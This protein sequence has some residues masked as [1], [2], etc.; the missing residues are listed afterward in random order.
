M[1]GSHTEED[2]GDK[3]EKIKLLGELEGRKWSLYNKQP[4]I[5]GT[6]SSYDLRKLRE[7][8]FRCVH[9]FAPENGGLIWILLFGLQEQAH[10]LTARGWRGCGL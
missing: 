5:D 2:T 4:Y 9:A 8:G 1:E 7:Y 6:F 3:G 10:L